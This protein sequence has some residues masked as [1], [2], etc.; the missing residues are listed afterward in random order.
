MLAWPLGRLAV[1]VSPIPQS[2]S[3]AH[4]L[5]H[6]HFHFLSLSLLPPVRF[7]SRWLR[8]WEGGDS[9]PHPAIDNDDVYVVFCLRCCSLCELRRTLVACWHGA[10]ARL[11][12][13]FVLQHFACIVRAAAPRNAKHCSSPSRSLS[14]GFG[15]SFCFSFSLNSSCC[16]CF[17]GSYVL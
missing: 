12:M 6:S 10:I 7:E 13:A 4:S 15:F 11:Y 1:V 8:E 3:P 14:F 17:G 5:A 9:D 16:P 2:R